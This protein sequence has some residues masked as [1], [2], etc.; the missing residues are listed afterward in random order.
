MPDKKTKRLKHSRYFITINTQ[1]HY[2]D[3]DNRLY[4]DAKQLNDS[5][6]EIME[7]FDK[8][9]E[10]NSGSKEDIRNIENDYSLELGTH[11]KGRRLHLH[12]LIQVH[13][14]AN[15]RIKFET[16]RGHFNKKYGKSI[17]FNSK[18]ITNADDIED[19]MNYMEKGKLNSSRFVK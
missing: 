16:I 18:L 9:I 2:A 13:H 17:H 19:I 14:Y 3:K 7:D 5:Y 8:L 6:K 1:N 11:N 12:A 10:F 4:E 15:I